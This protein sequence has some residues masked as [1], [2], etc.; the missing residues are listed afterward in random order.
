MAAENKPSKIQN[1]VA[2]RTRS[3]DV[4][5]EIIPLFV[6]HDVS[7]EEYTESLEQ[8]SEEMS[9][10]NSQENTID[11]GCKGY[12]P[13]NIDID[14][15]TFLNT[16]QLFKS[17]MLCM[18]QLDPDDTVGRLD[19]N[20][21]IIFPITKLCI[22]EKGLQV[23]Y[24]EY[25]IIRNI[26]DEDAKYGIPGGYTQMS[27]KFLYVDKTKQGKG[28]ASLL[29]G[30]ALVIALAE[31]CHVIK[32]D[33]DSDNVKEVVHNIYNKFGFKFLT[34]NEEEGDKYVSINDSE[35]Y[36]LLPS[37]D[38]IF[39]IIRERVKPIKGGKQKTKSKK[40]KN[41]KSKRVRQIL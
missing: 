21:E 11:I 2:S 13:E 6:H 32:L 9:R 8:F 16:Q 41:R 33:D 34:P 23:G 35:K 10:I 3:K 22:Y 4:D 29:M 12:W 39:R 19:E 20:G 36:L 24:V 40:N 14:M 30:Y 1:T 31:G 17:V 26:E 18:M 7:R 5:N 28:M 38:E 27:I 25:V 37:R 15:I